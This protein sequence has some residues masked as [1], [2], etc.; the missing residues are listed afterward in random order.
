MYGTELLLIMVN[1]LNYT[2]GKKSF[3]AIPV[4]KIF[5]IKIETMTQHQTPSM[6]LQN[7]LQR[8]TLLAK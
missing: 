4:L 3:L 1:G 2:Q 8:D 6:E 5:E 7:F